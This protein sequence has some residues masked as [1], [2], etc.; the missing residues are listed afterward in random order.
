MLKIDGRDTQ[1]IIMGPP[2]GVIVLADDTN[3]S[4]ERRKLPFHY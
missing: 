4:T 2:Q 1:S 3:M